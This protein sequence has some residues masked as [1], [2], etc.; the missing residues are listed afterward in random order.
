MN[1]LIIV[2][3]SVAIGLI[4]VGSVFG[5]TQSAIDGPVQ[6]SVSGIMGFVQISAEGGVNTDLPEGGGGAGSDGDSG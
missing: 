6:S 5:I 3:V 1:K 2:A 4:A